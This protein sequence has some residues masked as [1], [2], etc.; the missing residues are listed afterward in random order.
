MILQGETGTTYLTDE[1]RGCAA[2]LKHGGGLPSSIPQLQQGF[3][4]KGRAGITTRTR[5]LQSGKY[6]QLAKMGLNSC[7]SVSALFMYTLSIGQGRT[8][9]NHTNQATPHKEGITHHCHDLSIDPCARTMATVA[10]CEPR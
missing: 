2:G 7:S 8:R 1:R 4:E 5:C 9:S 3:D 10:T 6:Q